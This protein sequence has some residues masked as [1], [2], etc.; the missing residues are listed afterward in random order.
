MIAKRFRLGYNGSTMARTP[1]KTN[2]PREYLVDE[3]GRP[4]A[5]LLPIEEYEQLLE[6][7]EQRE[8]IRHLEK[9]KG[10]PGEAVPLEE[11]EAQLRTEGKLP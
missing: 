9:A 11:L 7:A 2:R 6:A 4:T 1:K 3:N 10:V 8:D 5:V